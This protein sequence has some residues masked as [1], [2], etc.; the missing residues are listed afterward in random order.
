[1]LMIRAHTPGAAAEI[2]FI[3]DNVR[4]HACSD[5]C[6]WRISMATSL[7]PNEFKIDKSVVQDENAVSQDDNTPILN[8]KLQSTR[9]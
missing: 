1:M 6:R 4:R 5:V 2:T 7:S 8:M 3:L 9:R